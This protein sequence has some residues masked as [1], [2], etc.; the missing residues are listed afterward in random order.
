MGL[1]F[2]VLTISGRTKLIFLVGDPIDHAK[3]FAEYA[4]ALDA[5]G[6]EAAYLP[7]HVPAGALAPFFGWAALGAEP[8]RCRRD[9][10]S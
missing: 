10:S 3:G 1:S 5:A 9:R 2:A 4:E 6:L 7:V 8:G